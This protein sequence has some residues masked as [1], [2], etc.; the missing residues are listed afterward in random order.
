MNSRRR[1]NSNVRH[2]FLDRFFRVTPEAKQ[3]MS[4]MSALSEE[5][6]C[7]EWMWGLEYALWKAVLDGQLKYGR[8][9]I[10]PEQITKLHALSKAC[11]G[12]IVFDDVIGETFIPQEQWE[13]MYESRDK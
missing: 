8:L 3:L 2:F 1:V 11:G 13:G 6:Y 12:W 9:E 5:A 7:A 10:T 4:Y